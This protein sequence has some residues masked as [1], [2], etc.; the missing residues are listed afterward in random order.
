[1]GRVDGR[2]QRSEVAGDRWLI[3]LRKLQLGSAVY[4][5]VW[6]AFRRHSLRWEV[7]GCVGR[8]SYRTT[9]RAP[10]GRV[11]RAVQPDRLASRL[12]WSSNVSSEG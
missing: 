8:A 7:T 12:R 6:S 11:A 3:A 1:M 10:M 4:T 5:Q 2:P 9:G